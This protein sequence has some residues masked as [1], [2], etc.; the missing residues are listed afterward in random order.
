LDGIEQSCSI[1]GKCQLEGWPVGTK[2]RY[3]QTKTIA[4]RLN[5]VNELKNQFNWEIPVYIDNLENTFNEHYSA[6]PDAAY[7]IHNNDIIYKSN[8]NNDGS[9][10]NTW[11]KEILTLDLFKSITENK[12]D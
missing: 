5:M 11:D 3:P 7:V 8:V 12:N 6:W 1:D 9:R 2:F 10:D 4:D